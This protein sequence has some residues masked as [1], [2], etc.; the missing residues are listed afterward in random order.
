MESRRFL[1]LN[2]VLMCTSDWKH[3]ECYVSCPRSFREYLLITKAVHLTVLFGGIAV[4]MT[5]TACII[6][7]CLKQGFVQHLSHF[8]TAWQERGNP[9]NK[10]HWCAPTPNLQMHPIDVN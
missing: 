8:K 9:I 6:T 10:N 4:D 2:A 3:I 7:N 1:F 5:D